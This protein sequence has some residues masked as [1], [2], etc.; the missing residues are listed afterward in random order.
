MLSDVPVLE[1]RDFAYGT[2]RATL[3]EGVPR[4]LAE[5]WARLAPERRA[6]VTQSA[7]AHSYYARKQ[8]Q[9]QA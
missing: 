4:F 8:V 9:E 1:A 6:A 7:R 3:E 5:A 2:R